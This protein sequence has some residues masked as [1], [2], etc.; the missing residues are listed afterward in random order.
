M[1]RVVINDSSFAFLQEIHINTSVTL[2]IEIT[3]MIKNVSE[4]KF[5]NQPFNALK[6][7]SWIINPVEDKNHKGNL[8]TN[9]YILFLKSKE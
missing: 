3:N 1:K 4:C 2:R 9:H 6:Y 5:G 8:L 7:L